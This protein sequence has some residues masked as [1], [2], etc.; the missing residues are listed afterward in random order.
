MTAIARLFQDRHQTALAFIVAVSAAHFGIALTL[1][2]RRLADFFT[3][4]WAG[5]LLAMIAVPFAIWLAANGL[6]AAKNKELGPAKALAA[7]FT[8]NRGRLATAAVL[9]ACY[10]LVNRSYRA[11]KVAIQRIE[12]FDSDPIF[13]AWDRALFG[14]DPWILT[15]QLLGPAGTQAI[16]ILYASWFF[17]I[18]FAFVFAASNGAFHRSGLDEV[19]ATLKK[20]FR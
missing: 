11:I 18:I 14:T 20:Q 10:A 2:E 8:D 5:E 17:V 9:L 7:L 3:L 4:Q 6:S 15:H 19:T 12:P 1:G 16:D 13:I